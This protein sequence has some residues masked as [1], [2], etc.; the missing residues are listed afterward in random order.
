[1]IAMFDDASRLHDEDRVGVTNGGDPV[2][3]HETCPFCAECR[4]GLLNQHLRARID[5]A[6]RLVEDQNCGVREEC[7]GDS[8]KL[9]LPHTHDATFVIDHRVVS[10]G[11]CT[12]EPVHV[13]RLSCGLDLLFGRLRIAV[14]NI[15]P[16]GATE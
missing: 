15:L 6:R 9:L 10:V 11:K 13:R 2:S 12:H 14:G 3:D 5:G 4:H 1:M 8:E 7:T 16:D